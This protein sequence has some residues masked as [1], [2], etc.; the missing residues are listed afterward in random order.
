MEQS[1]YPTGNESNNFI[2]Q[3][4]EKS[5]YT[6]LKSFS[7]K[8]GRGGLMS[9]EAICDCCKTRG[10]MMFCHTY[11]YSA[12]LK[13]SSSMYSVELVLCWAPVMLLTFFS[14]FLSTNCSV[15]HRQYQDPQEERG[16]MGKSTVSAI[17]LFHASHG[18]LSQV[19]SRVIAVSHV[20]FLTNSSSSTGPFWSIRVNTYKHSQTP[21]FSQVCS[22]YSMWAVIFCTTHQLGSSCNA[23]RL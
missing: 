15:N 6:P 4:L 13:S 22:Y 23:L 9:L 11:Y 14:C 5:V 20:A 10:I 8:R 18:P 16:H 7:D 17:F 3:L 1:Q 19:S 2:Q 21:A 12:G